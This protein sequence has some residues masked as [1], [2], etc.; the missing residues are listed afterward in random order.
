MYINVC[1]NVISILITFFQVDEIWSNCKY[2]CTSAKVCG[3][4][5]H[6]C[7]HSKIYNANVHRIG[8]RDGVDETRLVF[9]KARCSQFFTMKDILE[10]CKSYDRNL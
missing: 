7:S 1:I 5:Q 9:A 6:K 2:T 10:I 3:T 4:L 8:A